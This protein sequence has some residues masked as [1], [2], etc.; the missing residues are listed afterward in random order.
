MSSKPNLKIQISNNRVRP[1]TTSQPPTKPQATNPG[2]NHIHQPS[3]TPQSSKPGPSHMKSIVTRINSNDEDN[4]PL[5]IERFHGPRKFYEIV[6]SMAVSYSEDQPNSIIKLTDIP[7]VLKVIEDRR[8]LVLSYLDNPAMYPLQEIIHQDVKSTI[9]IHIGRGSG[10][11]LI[12][13]M[14]QEEFGV[15]LMAKT[16]YKFSQHII[17]N[18]TSVIKC[19]GQL[20]M[21]IEILDPLPDELPYQPKDATLQYPVKIP[22]AAKNYKIAMLRDPKMSD[23]EIRRRLVFM[24]VECAHGIEDQPILISI[25]ALDYDGRVLMNQMVCPRSYVNRYG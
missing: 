1:T 12:K 11:L 3:D 23:N 7:N 21:A 10:E 6:T 17:G 25:A 8:R 5:H 18:T 2:P 14:G 15:N 20:T 9:Y 24:D 16:S 22:D 19:R 13:K 4:Q